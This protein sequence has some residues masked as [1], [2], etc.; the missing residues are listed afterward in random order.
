MVFIERGPVMPPCQYNQRCTTVRFFVHL[1]VYGHPNRRWREDPS[2][3]FLL[4]I[5]PAAL[6]RGTIDAVPC[7]FRR[8]WAFLGGH[9]PGEGSR[10]GGIP[11]RRGGKGGRAPRGAHRCPASPMEAGPARERARH[12]PFR[13]PS[14][15]KLKYP[16]PP[17]MR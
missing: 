11:A 2:A 8:S 10:E 7:P 5:I 3:W 9:F 4:A 15:A 13:R 6:D 17:T 1:E 12:Y 14:L 16:F